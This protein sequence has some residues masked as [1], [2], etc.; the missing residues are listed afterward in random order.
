MWEITEWRLRFQNI[1]Q[2]WLDKNMEIR[3]SVIIILYILLLLFISRVTYMNYVSRTWI[4]NKTDSAVSIGNS[5][6][7][8]RTIIRNDRSGDG[9]SSRSSCRWMQWL[10][11]L[12]S[13]D[14]DNRELLAC[15][16]HANTHILIRPSSNIFWTCYL[17]HMLYKYIWEYD[18]WWYGQGSPIWSS[19][20]V[21]LLFLRP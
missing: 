8:Q 18:G 14:S 7:P 21:W 6:N 2:I 3:H 13:L 19:F 20:D 4:N 16:S 1:I 5:N 11:I 12:I 17:L 10:T 15:S 9:C